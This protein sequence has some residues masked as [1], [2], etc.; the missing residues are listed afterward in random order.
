MLKLNDKVKVVCKDDFKYKKKGKI[1]G[2]KISN[3]PLPYRVEFKKGMGDYSIEMLK[4]G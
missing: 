3:H 4:K 1:I 2:I